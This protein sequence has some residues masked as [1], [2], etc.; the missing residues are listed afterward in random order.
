[1]LHF[2]RI[3][4][5]L[6]YFPLNVT[7][8]PTFTPPPP[9]KTKRLFDVIALQIVPSCTEQL[10]WDENNKNISRVAPA[11]L[12]RSKIRYHSQ[13]APSLAATAETFSNEA[14]MTV[15]FLKFDWVAGPTIVLNS[16]RAFV[17][18]RKSK[19]F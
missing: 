8:T 13:Q 16:A 7:Y 10:K 11:F 17:A 9:H 18:K 5:G 12:W 6:L 14:G 3:E 1:M 2:S 4:K 15:F 19:I